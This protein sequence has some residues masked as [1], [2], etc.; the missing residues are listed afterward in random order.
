MG[1]VRGVG[2]RRANFNCRH[3]KPLSRGI[4]ASWG[5]TLVEVLI[6]VALAAM[7][8]A[9]LVP[10]FFLSSRLNS[11]DRTRTVGLNVAQSRLEAIRTLP[12]VQVSTATLNALESNTTDSRDARFDGP[13][14]H[15]GDSAKVYHVA[16]SVTPVTNR[17]YKYVT[18]TVRWDGAPTSGQPVILRTAVYSRP[19]SPDAVGLR[20][21][22]PNETGKDPSVPFHTTPLT[23][24]VTVDPID[25]PSVDHVDFIV[26]ADNGSKIAEG[27]VD[28][29][30]E[31]ELNFPR[32]QYEWTWEGSTTA[33]DGNY[34][35]TATAVG[36]DAAYTGDMWQRP[37]KLDC[38]KNPD[39]PQWA[40][41]GLTA[42]AS[43]IRVTWSPISSGD[44]RC[45]VVERQRV[46]D[47]DGSSSTYFHD[48]P[49][50][51]TTLIDR[52]S[53]E[54]GV[55]YKYRVQSQDLSDLTS[56]WSSWTNEAAS[57]VPLI[58]GGSATQ[59]PPPVSSLG[60]AQTTSIVA[61]QTTND[62][63]IALTWP[64]SAGEAG[65]GVA[66]YFVYRS[67][68][69]PVTDYV[70]AGTD[71][72]S[73]I[74]VVKIPPPFAP[75]TWGDTSVEWRGQYEY[76]VSVADASLNES[77]RTRSLSVPV[78]LTT[79]L[80]TLT[81]HANATASLIPKGQKWY[82]LFSFLSVEG[83]VVYPQPWGITQN[84]NK[85]YVNG[86]KGYSQ[87]LTVFGRYLV[88]AYYYVN[89]TGVLVG[90]ITEMVD[91][92]N[93]RDMTFMYQGQ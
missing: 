84:S 18:V 61:G 15:P 64:P 23:G 92:A 37:V 83:G 60:A 34:M 58:P 67:Q 3:A 57:A 73:P 36:K 59:A 80:W 29:Y 66:Y 24:R 31:G 42:G 90:S 81:V 13:W 56:K 6:A 55:A 62:R 82:A 47:T 8:L 48:L 44:L 28:N 27:T 76:S 20:V 35:F 79:G 26:T 25:A 7:L 69:N 65:G 68:L 5:F 87:D 4:A 32:L 19:F 88:T 78:D 17:D 39:P 21:Y 10:V 53:L 52:R 50:W 11:I 51:S 54:A 91:L 12:Y 86:T 49:P 89:S 43:A 70:D 16:Y 77:S 75:Y 45:Y 9:V 85:L 1:S 40:T 38:Y 14:K 71:W 22:S 33:A 46:D 63:Q 30:Q 2:M 74:H 41:E 72:S 93:R